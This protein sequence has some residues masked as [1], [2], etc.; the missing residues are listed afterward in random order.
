MKNAA[1]P[2]ITTIVAIR[3]TIGRKSKPFCSWG[4]GAAGAGAAC[5]GAGGVAAGFLAGAFFSSV[6]ADGAG[7]SS[8]TVIVVLVS[9]AGWGAGSAVSGAFGGGTPRDTEPPP[10]EPLVVVVVVVDEEE[11]GVASYKPKVEKLLMFT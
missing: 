11:A 9:G 2:P 10:V 5:A 1:A 6:G 4:A 3:S 7:F 8:G